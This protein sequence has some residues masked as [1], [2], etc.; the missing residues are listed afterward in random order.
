MPV[1]IKASVYHKGCLLLELGVVSRC[2]RPLLVQALPIPDAAAQEFGP[3]RHRDGRVQPLR[4]QSPKVWVMPTEVVTGR[5]P[6]QADASPETAHFLLQ[7]LTAH[8]LEIFVHLLAPGW[9]NPER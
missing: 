9:D 2:I 3:R 7:L 6:V 8:S 1:V 5:I 4:K